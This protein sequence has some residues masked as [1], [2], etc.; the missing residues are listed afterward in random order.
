MKHLLAPA[1]RNMASHSSALV[2][3]LL[4]TDHFFPLQT[5]EHTRNSST[6]LAPGKSEKI[7]S[8][9]LSQG[10]SFWYLRTSDS[11]RPQ[12]LLSL[13]HCLCQPS[14][15]PKSSLFDIGNGSQP[16]PGWSHLGSKGRRCGHHAY[17][18]KFC[19]DQPRPQ[20][21]RSAL[22]ASDPQPGFSIQSPL[23]SYYPEDTFPLNI[24]CAGHTL[25]PPQFQVPI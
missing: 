25:Y 8:L 11:Q 10:A 21:P 15:L 24:I 13:C 3:A 5:D 17:T 7:V 20:V 16:H 2:S 9:K 22:S 18:A 4:F 19:S 23:V 6:L 1:T 12:H 14:H